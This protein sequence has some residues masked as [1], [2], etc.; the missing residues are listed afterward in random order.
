MKCC[1]IKLANRT[2][3][4]PISQKDQHRCLLV[5]L[6]NDDNHRASSSNEDLS[7]R[8][9]DCEQPCLSVLNIMLPKDAK[10]FNTG[11]SIKRWANKRPRLKSSRKVEEKEPKLVDTDSI[12]IPNLIEELDSGI[13]EEILDEIDPDIQKLLEETHVEESSDDKRISFDNESESRKT[14]K[15]KRRHRKKSKEKNRVKEKKNKHKIKKTVSFSL[16]KPPTPQTEQIIRVDVVS[17]YSIEFETGESNRTDCVLSTPEKT[18]T[19]K[20]YLDTNEQFM[21]QLY[22]TQN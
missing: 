20:L 16:S 3:E 1:A 9:S 7:D 14:H 21:Y 13:K 5:L 10:S 4:R 22:C 8:Q 11:S 19:E 18:S 15:S 2:D 12:N 17:N 6:E